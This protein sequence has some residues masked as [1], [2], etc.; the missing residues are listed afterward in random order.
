M[1]SA[2]QK[3]HAIKK[4]HGLGKKLVLEKKKETCVLVLV[5]Q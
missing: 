1:F 4:Q 3:I 2:F 5:L